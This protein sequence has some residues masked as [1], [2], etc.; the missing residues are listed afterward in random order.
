MQMVT[1]LFSRKSSNNYTESVV[2]HFWAGTSLS[3][4]GHSGYAQGCG[5]SPKTLREM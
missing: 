1:E 4:K 5:Q 3:Q 2:E